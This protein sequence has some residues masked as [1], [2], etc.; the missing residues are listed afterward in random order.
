[1]G[2]Q[3]GQRIVLYSKSALWWVQPTTAEPFT[4]VQSD[5]TWSCRI[6]PGTSYAALLVKP[7]YHPQKRM[8]VLPKKGGDVLTAV[9]VDGP[10]LLRSSGKTLSFDGYDWQIR[11]TLDYP[12][13]TRN[14]YDPANAW[15]DRLGS[16]H[17]RIAP[18]AGHL[19]SAEINLPRSLGYGTYR[20]VTRGLADLESGAAFSIS[21][22]DDEHP[23]REMDIEVWQQGNT[24]TKNGGFVIQPYYVPA[25]SVPFQTPEGLAT[26]MLRW[27][28]G[29]ASFKAFKGS[30]S[31]WETQAW[32]Q[33]VF[34]SGVPSPGNESI[35]LN[36]YVA[37]K[38]SKLLTAGNEVTVETF[39]FLP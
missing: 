1:M 3:P 32:A 17:L 25:N 10:K 9:C 27:E 33:H 2:V 22:V 24:T 12:L 18:H 11:Q 29:R 7:G 37:S 36:L 8:E 5:S 19:T 26:F 30:A 13:G 16:L 39:E 35:H 21:T 28:P 15:T 20:F 34:T 31:K 14:D 23:F 4:T 38:E 6:H